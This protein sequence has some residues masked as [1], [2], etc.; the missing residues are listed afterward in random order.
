MDQH[1][2]TEPFTKVYLQEVCNSDVHKLVNR[3]LLPV[4]EQ[5]VCR[6]SR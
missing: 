1:V 2:A 5:P 6:G 3:L 4:P